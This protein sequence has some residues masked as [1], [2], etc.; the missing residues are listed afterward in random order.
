[1]EHQLRRAVVWGG[2]SKTAPSSGLCRKL[3][4]GAGEVRVVL[5]SGHGSRKRLTCNGVFSEDRR[6]LSSWAHR[7]LLLKTLWSLY[8][9]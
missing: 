6:R 8:I 4:A 2:L 9:L 5:W 1:M 7:S 3:G